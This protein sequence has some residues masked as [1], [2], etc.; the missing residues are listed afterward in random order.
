MEVTHDAGT[1]G[2]I[3]LAAKPKI[4]A[5]LETIAGGD[6][7]EAANADEVVIRPGTTVTCRL[8]V[9]RN[10]FDDRIQFEV[11]NLPHGVIVDNIGLNGVLIPE[12]ETSRVLYLTAA[13]WV[14]AT[15]RQF[16]A[17]AKAEGDQS[18]APLWLRVA[19]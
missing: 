10:G 17:V 7:A 15:C 18:S 14:P 5:R 4:V 1:L 13:D 19:K 3:K 6:A 12:K 11:D 2:T 9:E 16:F 8:S